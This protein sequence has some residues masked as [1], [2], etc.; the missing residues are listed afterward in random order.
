MKVYTV[1]V[2]QDTKHL[3][4]STAE[5]THVGEGDAAALDPVR[6]AGHGAG[7]DPAEAAQDAIV[8]AELHL[9]NGLG[10]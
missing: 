9:V 4:T 5:V 2:V 7:R 10:V 6:A 1:V 3:W 8:A